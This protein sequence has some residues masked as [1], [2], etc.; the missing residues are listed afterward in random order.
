MA[1]QLDGAAP[2]VP[3]AV[4]QAP[5]VRSEHDASPKQHACGQGFGLH[6]EPLPWYAPEQLPRA[7]IE[8]TGDRAIPMPGFHW[9]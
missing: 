9:E 8:S 3:P 1:A 4:W 2:G 7:Y 5:V 6:D